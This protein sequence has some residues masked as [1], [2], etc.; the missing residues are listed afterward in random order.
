MAAIK[1]PLAM[2]LRAAGARSV[3][4]GP[5][6]LVIAVREVASGLVALERSKAYAARVEV[7]C[8]KIDL[9]ITGLEGRRMRCLE[10]ASALD[11][12]CDLAEKAIEKAGS[13]TRS[14]AERE[15]MKA[16]CRKLADAIDRLVEADV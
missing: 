11:D 12:L 14:P 2:G 13:S 16:R 8:A 10:L 7:C 9:A 5:G 6:A 15:A 4:S 1:I 3:V